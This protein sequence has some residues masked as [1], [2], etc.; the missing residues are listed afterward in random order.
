M[1]TLA[2]HL[3]K[4]FSSNFDSKMEIY[5]KLESKLMSSVNNYD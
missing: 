1:Q 2:Q 4:I 3:R 5:H